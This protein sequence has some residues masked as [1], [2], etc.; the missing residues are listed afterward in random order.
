MNCTTKTITQILRKNMIFLIIFL[1]GIVFSTLME[2]YPLKFMQN[3]LDGLSE[4]NRFSTIFWLLFCWYMCRLLGALASTV[5]GFA[6]A[7]LSTKISQTLRSEIFDRVT[8][9]SYSTIE[10]QSASESIG[11]II[12]DVNSIGKTLLSTS[13]YIIQNVFLFVWATYFLFKTDWVLYLSCVPL[14]IV[15]WLAGNLVSKKSQHNHRV[16]RELETELTDVFLGYFSGAREIFTL[17]MKNEYMCKFSKLNIMLKSKQFK[18]NGLNV[19]LSNI[20]EVLWPVATVISLGVGGYR[21][22]YC[23]LS[24]GSLIAFM[25]YIQWAINPI[26][27]LSSYKNE[28]QETKVSIERISKVLE[29]FPCEE[30]KL[31]PAKA[32][33]DEIKFSNISYH[34]PVGGRGIRDIS[35]A[36]QTGCLYSFIGKTG[37]GK[38]T[39]GK[40]LAGLYQPDSGQIFVN[41]LP[42]NLAEHR[43]SRHVMCAY[44]DPYVFDGS[45]INN[46]TL[47][48]SKKHLDIESYEKLLTMLELGNLSNVDDLSS[49]GEHGLSTGQKQRIAIGRLLY[50]A[51]NVFI[52]DEATSAIDSATE[53]AILETLHKISQTNIVIFISHRLSSVLQTDHCFIV[54]DGRIIT[55]GDPKSMIQE[56]EKFRALFAEQINA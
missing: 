17:G 8:Q 25:W 41:G 31:I 55:E 5:S 20:L 34:Y 45:M 39:I 26:S 53:K 47:D 23:N 29:R 10:G 43:M 19:A 11:S 44:S 22:L 54:E 27:Q 46:I 50:N 51:P 6:S 49:Q 36:V 3:I 35:F 4:G 18:A 13:Q 56:S 40:L 1:M 14:G 42:Q 9:S 33:V 38:S 48:F 7:A 28:I 15:M 21:V 24:T 12:T 30:Q 32:Q 16:R 52:I 2:I 37:S